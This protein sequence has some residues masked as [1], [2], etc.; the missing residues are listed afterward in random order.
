[1]LFQ[2]LALFALVCALQVLLVVKA[3]DVLTSLLD[4]RGDAAASNGLLPT[5]LGGRSA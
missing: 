3:A 4:R 5:L 2:A 1:M